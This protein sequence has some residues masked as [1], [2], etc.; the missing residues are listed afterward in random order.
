MRTINEII[1]EL[2]NHPDYM[3]SEIF[4]WSVYLEEVNEHLEEWSNDNQNEIF[5]P[6]TLDELSNNLK[7]SIIDNAQGT[8]TCGYY[9]GMNPYLRITRNSQT[10]IIEIIEE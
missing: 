7:E 10:S 1:D 4:T 2:K 8:L 3:V 5:E 9:Y 6:I